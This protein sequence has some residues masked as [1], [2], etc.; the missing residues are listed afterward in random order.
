MN[1]KIKRKIGAWALF[2]L[3]FLFLQLANTAYWKIADLAYMF[4]GLAFFGISSILVVR[5]KWRSPLM[6]PPDGYT[7]RKL[8]GGTAELEPAKPGVV[9]W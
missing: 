4:L 9:D 6:N 8:K 5:R 1:P 2:L 7:H 3:F